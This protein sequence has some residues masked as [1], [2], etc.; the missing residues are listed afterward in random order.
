[1]IE[2]IE[3]CTSG[4]HPAMVEPIRMRDFFNMRLQQIGYQFSEKTV[5][6]DDEVVTDGASAEEVL[7]SPV[8]TAAA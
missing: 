5:H 3:E 4:E 1:M 6:A 7:P 2:I 8:A